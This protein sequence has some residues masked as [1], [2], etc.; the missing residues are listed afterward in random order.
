M[1]DFFLITSFEN[2]INL[3]SII[4][5]LLLNTYKFS[6]FAGFI[7]QPKMLQSINLS[8]YD[9]FFVIWNFT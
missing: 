5:G 4:I 1:N 8:S 3:H 6:S 7:L 2:L 9:L